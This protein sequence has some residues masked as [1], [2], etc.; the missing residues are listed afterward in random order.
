MKKIILTTI[1]FLIALSDLTNAQWFWQNPLPQG[2]TLRDV[3]VFDDNNA[4]AVGDAGTIIRTTDGGT[5]WII[6]YNELNITTFH[7]INN[8]TGWAIGY[9]YANNR[10]IL[11]TDDGGQNWNSQYSTLR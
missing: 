5:S 8:N 3:H 10:V 9:D 2:N 1:I 6:Q 11:R 4:I 7:F